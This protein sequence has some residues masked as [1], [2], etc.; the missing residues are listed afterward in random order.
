MNDL[1]LIIPE[2]LPGTLTTAEIDALANGE[3]RARA[4]LPG[5]SQTEEHTRFVP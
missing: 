5:L 3:T 1:A 2:Q 4:D